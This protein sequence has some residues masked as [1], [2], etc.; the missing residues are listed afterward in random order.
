MLY[1][2]IAR[3]KRKTI[4]V[5]ANFLFLIGLM[6][7]AFGY[8]MA[9]NAKL[10]IILA[11]IISGIYMVMTTTQSVQVVMHLNHARPLS[12]DE[13]PQLYHIVEDMAMVAHV[14]M[15]AL[16]YMDD[17]SIN[18]FATGNSPQHAAIAVTKGSLTKLTRPELEGVIGHEMSHIQNYD[19]RLQSIGVALASA[20]TFLANVANNLW[21][22]HADDD[23]NQN[24]NQW[25]N[26]LYLMLSILTLVLGPLA[27]SIAQMALSRNREYL[28]DAGSANLTRNPQ[29]L[30]DALKAIEKDEQPMQNVAPSSASLYLAEPLNKQTRRSFFNHLF[31][32]HP[33]LEDRIARLQQ[34]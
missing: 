13:A 15:P 4:F 19:I 12:Q 22:W 16:Y 20:I 6:G 9:H 18:A 2:Q 21:F 14:P 24:N 25:L 11:L 5:M 29:E 10:G 23:N 30:I 31:D 34:M 1:Q 32:T 27:A 7:A 3:N 8:Y 17:P 33:P 26:L 28:A